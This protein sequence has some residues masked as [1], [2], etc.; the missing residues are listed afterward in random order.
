MGRARFALDGVH[1]LV[2]FVHNPHG[3][4]AVA[5]MVE[6]FAP[7]RLAMMEDAGASRTTAASLGATSPGP[8]V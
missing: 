6:R 4:E 2:D 3:F 5:G 7:K 1:V 8:P